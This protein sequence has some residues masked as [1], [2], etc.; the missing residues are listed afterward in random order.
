MSDLINL[1]FF[2]N[3]VIDANIWIASEVITVAALWQAGVILIT[4]FIA[5]LLTPPCRS[6]LERLSINV[7]DDSKLRIV[8]TTFI[9]VITP[10]IWVLLLWGAVEV[11]DTTY[12]PNK[13]ISIV[14][15]AVNAVII[16]I[17]VAKFVNIK[18]YVKLFAI[19]IALI[20]ILNIFD[21]LQPALN[22]LDGISVQIGEIKL[23]VLSVSKGLFYLI[24]LLWLANLFSRII[25][26]KINSLPSLTPSVQ[27]LLTK[28]I[29]I[30]LVVIAGMVA[31][32]AVGVDLT[33]FAVFGG[34]LGVGIGFGLQKIVA[35][36]VSGIILLLDKS[37]KPGDTI[38]VSGTYG[39][40]QSL[41]ARYVSVVTRDGIEHLIPNEELITTRVEN[42]SFSNLRIRQ[43]IPIGV[44]YNSDIRE[45]INICSEAA[46]ENSRVLDTPSPICLLKGFGDSSVDLEVRFWVVD[47]QNGLTNVKS[48]I[49]LDIWDRFNANGIEIPFPQRDIHLKTVIPEI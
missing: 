20:A 26:R 2:R 41:G 36:F 37:I 43:K 35:N 31:I 7:V 45:A 47:P 46:L 24:V 6:C 9:S 19:I 18:A 27:V 28:F 23:T 44:S 40:I 10:T 38:G 30:F 17:F 49:L 33:A 32:N 39:W 21:L 13:L 15:S 11:A 8:C 1:D 42:W 3:L 4:L 5:K 34:A 25:E 29:K 48:E 14:V 22:L 12:W 16:I